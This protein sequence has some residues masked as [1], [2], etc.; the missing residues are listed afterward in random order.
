MAAAAFPSA[1]ALLLSYNFL[2]KHGIFFSS[3]LCQF[4]PNPSLPLWSPYHRFR[5]VSHCACSYHTGKLLALSFF[6]PSS[7]SSRNSSFIFFVSEKGGFSS[8]SSSAFGTTRNTT[9]SRRS[10]QGIRF[11]ELLF[12][13]DPVGV[14]LSMCSLGLPL[15]GRNLR[16]QRF[17]Q[18]I[19]R[20]ADSWQLSS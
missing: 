6:S 18:T 3:F 2:Q 20:I 10:R 4:L 13:F 19:P 11:S 16:R 7:G 8:S 15:L 1:L 12:S 9:S 5:L 17:R 14:L